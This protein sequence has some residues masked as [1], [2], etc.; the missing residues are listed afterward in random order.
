MRNEN[1]QWGVKINI[2]EQLMEGTYPY[3]PPYPGRGCAITSGNTGNSSWRDMCDEVRQQLQGHLRTRLA[4]S[5]RHP[6]RLGRMAIRWEE[7]ERPGT[8]AC[9]YMHASALI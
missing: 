5:P 9:T 2:H 1:G 7:G 3:H 6:A 8:W 4:F